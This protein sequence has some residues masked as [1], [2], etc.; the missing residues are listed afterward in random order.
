MHLSLIISIHKHVCQDLAVN[1][2]IWFMLPPSHNFKI[3]ETWISSADTLFLIFSRRQREEKAFQLIPTYKLVL[4]LPRKKIKSSLEQIIESGNEFCISMI[5]GTIY[6][7][8]LGQGFWAK[9]KFYETSFHSKYAVKSLFLEV[10]YH[11]RNIP[12]LHHN[13]LKL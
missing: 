11:T 13:D 7:I 6:V 8:Y 5:L 1:K 4:I 2:A 12:T 3:R 9:L 10:L